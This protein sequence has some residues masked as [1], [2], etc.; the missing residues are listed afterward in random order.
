MI[1]P[2]ILPATVSRSPSYHSQGGYTAAD[3]YASGI[4]AREIVSTA[5]GLWPLNEMLEAGYSLSEVNQHG[6][7]TAFNHKS[8]NGSWIQSD[9]DDGSNS[10]ANAD[11]AALPSSRAVAQHDSVTSAHSDYIALQFRQKRM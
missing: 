2:L 10:V 11:V 4:K 8:Q 1:P 5:W 9:E 6:I 3:L 7:S